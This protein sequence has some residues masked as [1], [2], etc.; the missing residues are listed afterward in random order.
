MLTSARKSQLEFGVWCQWPA[1]NIASS[2][3]GTIIA[4]QTTHLQTA[5]VQASSSREHHSNPRPQLVDVNHISY[6]EL[7]PMITVSNHPFINYIPQKKHV[8]V[9]TP[10]FCRPWMVKTWKN[11]VKLRCAGL[12]NKGSSGT[13]GRTISGASHTSSDLMPCAGSLRRWMTAGCVFKGAVPTV[14]AIFIG[15]IHQWI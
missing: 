7:E 1:S 10:F 13:P 12:P 3:V 4:E 6:I 8:M 11:M 14:M 2:T 15:T 5:L 9:T